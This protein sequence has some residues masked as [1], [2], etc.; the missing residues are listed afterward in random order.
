MGL[1]RGELLGLR[2]VDVDLNAGTLTIEKTVQRTRG[3]LH[4]QDAKTERSESVLPLPEITKRTLEDHRDRQGKERADLAEAWKDYG[5]VFPSET[6][7][8]MEPRNLSRHF[9]GLR[10]RAG[11]PDVRLHDLRHTVVSVLMD[12][13]VPPH[14][15]QAIAR[16]S[17]VKITLRIYAHEP[18]CNARCPRQT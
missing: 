9:A 2:W 16:H 13:G 6:G 18:G 8:P 14:V 3:V 1:R 12:L 7:T 4:I 17:D 5:L 10:A 11:L 15:V